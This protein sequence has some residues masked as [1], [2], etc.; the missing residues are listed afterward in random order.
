MCWNL[1]G[2][3]GKTKIRNPNIE[4]NVGQES[5]AEGKFGHLPLI[6]RRFPFFWNVVIFLNFG[7]QPNF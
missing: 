2:Q 1:I 4:T 7:F 3:R 6:T 5:S